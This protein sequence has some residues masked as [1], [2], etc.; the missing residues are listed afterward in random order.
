ML[1]SVGMDDHR[2]D[3]LAALRWLPPVRLGKSAGKA[4]REFKEETDPA[5]RA[6]R[7]LV[8]GD[9]RRRPSRTITVSD[10][11]IVAGADAELRAEALTSRGQ[12]RIQVRL[13]EAPADRP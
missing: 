4:I 12:R 6:S 5:P 13:A 10:A 11:D 2:P 9:A 8:P 3:R 7:P 1:G